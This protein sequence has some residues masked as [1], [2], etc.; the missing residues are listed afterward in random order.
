MKSNFFYCIFLI[1]GLHGCLQASDA[2]KPDTNEKNNSVVII[3]QNAPAQSRFITMPH[4]GIMSSTGRSDIKYV[5]ANGL[6][7]EFSPRS[8]LDTLIL[9]TTD[10]YVDI[11]HRYKGLETLFFLFKAGDTITIRYDSLNYP[12]ISG[13]VYPEQELYYNFEYNNRPK[14]LY[15]DIHP[16]TVFGSGIFILIDEKKKK[17]HNIDFVQ[18]LYVPLDP[19]K[20]EVDAYLKQYNSMLNQESFQKDP[21]QKDYYYFLYQT[22]QT[23]FQLKGIY[24]E[25]PIPVDT[26]IQYYR[27]NDSLINRIAYSHYITL[28]LLDFQMNA[29]LRKYQTKGSGGSTFDFKWVF[30]QLSNRKEIIPSGTLDLMLSFTL[31]DIQESHSVDD[32]NKYSR[33]YTDITGRDVQTENEM[34]EHPVISTDKDDLRLKDL[35]GN[36][37]SF[38]EIIKKHAGKVIYV[39]YWASWC[40]PCRSAMPEAKK[41]RAEY[42]DKGVVFLYLA[43]NDREAAWKESIKKEQ[44]DYLGENYLILN[45]KTSKTIENLKIRE[46]PRYMIYDREGK[47]Q[48][49]RAPGPNSKELREI[50]DR[51]G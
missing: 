20:V 49:F 44:L 34:M 11:Q 23:M 32:F 47:L 30:D 33:K 24:K 35:N 31:K 45:G 38:T 9:P 15:F 48:Y 13:K 4:G 26:L 14:K 19:V 29:P 51:F 12:I 6:P 18:E 40:A 41:I 27:F 8:D 16:L 42:A 22:K 39:D 46:I 50:L 1:I 10:G 36:E 28:F 17:N 37:Y 2:N 21:T 3:F 25:K 7:Q 43:L 5:A